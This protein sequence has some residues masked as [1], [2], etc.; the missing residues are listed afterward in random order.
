MCGIAGIYGLENLDD[1]RDRVEKMTAK[2]S[3]RGPDAEGIYAG[4]NAI[5]GHRRLSIIDINPSSNQPFSSLDGRYTMVYN[6]ELY[7]YRDIKSQ[8]S[9][10]DFRTD[11]DTEVVLAAFMKWGMKALQL[12]NGMFAFAFWDNEEEK[13]WIGRD[14]LGIKP[15]Y[16]ANAGQSVLFA[17]EMR[18]ILASGLVKPKLD[19]ASLV[20]YL[21]Y[22]TVHAPKT[23]IEGVFMLNPGC[24]VQVSDTDF[25]EVE[26][27]KPWQSYHFDS[28][29]VVVQKNIRE[30]LTKA[31]DLRLVSDVPF[32]AFLSGGI[33]SSLIVG[34]IAERLGKSIDTFNVSFDDSAF[35]EAIYARKVAKK[36]NSNHHE[37]Q[38]SPNDLLEALPEALAAMD[39]PSGDGPNTWIVSRETKKQGISMAL[40][41]LGGDEVFAGY[42]VFTRIPYVA[43][44]NW[45]LSFPKPLRAL[46]GNLLRT[47]KPGFQSAKTK[48]IL[49]SDYFDLQHLYPVFRKV[50]LDDSV[51]KLL[52]K[53]SLSSNNVFDT[54]QSLEQYSEFG[55][56]PTLGR[57]G[58]AEMATYMQNVLL[59]DT[60]QMSMA[61][62]LEVRVPFL[63]HELVE[64]S[65]HISDSLKYPHSPKKL[66]VDSFSDLLPK[67]IVDR[68]K[69]G[70]VLPWENWL[71]K[72]LKSFAEERLDFLR[73]TGYFDAAAIDNLW[74]K[75][76]KGDPTVTWSRVWPLITLADWMKNNHIE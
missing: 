46:I 15:L 65:M 76:L 55:A 13:L 43:E 56:L 28:D 6:G 10:H 68:P 34:I 26:Y 24:Y 32:G 27:W 57:I 11:S 25:K 73:T 30:K 72:E 7:N 51:S 5:L 44:H 20:D 58:I 19:E 3:H 75:F 12:F 52:R 38:L 70:F 14:R 8:L 63:D 42:D 61:H 74:S 39:H 41:G 47:A 37:I 2:I 64:Y 21:R 33:D 49:L 1:A 67:E 35:S 60:D 59:R 22:Q 66:L 71:K 48:E 53:K 9:D 50:L 54:I 4:K 16:Y 29:P 45:I 18:S 31:V 40:S 17:S 62:A 69:M 36:F 23:M